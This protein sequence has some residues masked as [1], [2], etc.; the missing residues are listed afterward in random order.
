YG[1]G[2][3]FHEAGGAD[4]VIDLKTMG[5]LEGTFFDTPSG[6]FVGRAAK[7]PR[8]IQGGVLRRLPSDFDA[9]AYLRANPDVAAS[10][11]DAGE[12][13]RR[14]GWAEGR[15]LGPN[16]R[17][18][19]IRLILTVTPGRSGSAYLCELLKGVPGIYADHE[20][21]PKFSDVMRSAQYNA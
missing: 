21:E 11:A 5:M 17:L 14:Y 12:H 10:G 16:W 19:G 7:P 18:E 6:M 8:P 3:E 15:I 20:P 1:T 9:T 2:A 13:Y 4:S